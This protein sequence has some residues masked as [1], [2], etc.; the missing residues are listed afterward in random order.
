[1]A[2]AA[3]ATELGGKHRSL[4]NLVPP[5]KEGDPSPNPSG[6]PKGSFSIRAALK[7]NLRRGYQDDSDSDDGEQIG[8]LAR[9][10]AFDLAQ[11]IDEGD[12]DKVRSIATV[13]DQAEGRP[14]ERVEHSG[15]TS[16]QASFVA[17]RAPE[18][19]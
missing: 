4:Q 1:M 13:I 12:A 7:R 11:A 5:W 17:P 18:T 9:K 16:I 14:Q 15:T 8:T 6:R 19:P 3:D 10:L 2:D